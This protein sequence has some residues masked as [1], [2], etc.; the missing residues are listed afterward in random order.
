MYMKQLFSPTSIAIVGASR[1]NTKVGSVVLKNHL[2]SGYKGKLYPI[3]PQ[4]KKIM[5]LKCYPSVSSIGKNVDCAI[6]AVPSRFVLDVVEDCGKAKVPYLVILSSG[7]GESG[8]GG[9]RHEADLKKLLKKYKIRVVGPNCLG[10]VN[11]YSGLNT[12]FVSKIPLQGSIGFVSQSGAMCSAILDWSFQ[13][14]FGFSKFVSIGNKVDLTEADFLRYLA[15]D[16]QT[17]VILL[18]IEGLRDGKSFMQ[19]ACYASR[20]KPVLVLKAGRTQA[21]AK[22]AMSHTGSLTG[23]DEVYS[24]AFAQSGVLRVNTTQELFDIGLAFSTLRAPKKHTV[25]IVTNSGGPGILASDSVADAD[26]RL[27]KISSLTQNK[28]KK[29]LPPQASTHN[30]IDVVGDADA[31][32]YSRALNVVVADKDVGSVLALMCP[33]QMVDMAAVGKSIIAASR[34]AGIPIVGCFMGGKSMDKGRAVLQKGGIPHFEH[35][36]EAMMVLEKIGHYY[37]EMKKQRVVTKS[38]VVKANHKRAATILSRAQATHVTVLEESEGMDLLSCYKIPTVTHQLAKTSQDAVRL[39]KKMGFPVVLKIASE[40]IAHKTDAGGVVVGVTSADDV[41]KAY[42][43]IMKAVKKKKPRAKLLGVTVESLAQGKEVIVGI[44]RDPQF[45]PVLTFGLGGVYVEVLKD[46]SRRVLPVS[47]K[48]VLDMI[49]EIKSYPL[50]TGV[51]GEKGVNLDKLA[52]VL[53]KLGQLVL[54]HDSIT[55][56]EINPLVVSSRGVVAVDVLCTLK[57]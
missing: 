51:R 40:D 26:F 7:F 28:L 46:V 19:A 22:A 49:S 38:V 25:A 18:Y 42:L 37:H 5:G 48:G 21:G 15:D 44:T 45:G 16:A 27:A 34:R 3:N 56:I 57:K 47:R 12:S 14:G 33:Q 32:R 50:L 2:D 31:D 10:V 23:S 4:A 13:E 8:K 54:D 9:K 30:P 20:K 29:F 55:A 35:P 11:P 41:K 39:S 43:Q 17:K 36:E 6:I 24:A 52:D 53:L 1:K